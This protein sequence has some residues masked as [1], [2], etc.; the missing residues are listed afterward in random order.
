MK[1]LVLLINIIFI[2]TLVLVGCGDKAK[3]NNSKSANN[4][5]ASSISADKHTATTV[6]IGYVD[7][8]KSF[9]SGLLGIAQEKG[10]I[11]NELNKIGVKVELVPFVG[12]GP[13]INEALASKSIDLGSLG[14]VPALLGKSAGINTELIASGG[15]NTDAAL[16]VPADSKITSIKELKGKRIATMKGSF[17]HRTLLEMLKANGM[18]AND[19]Q[20][21]NMTAPDAETAIISKTVDATVNPAAN[22]QRLVLKKYGKIILDSTKNPEWKGAGGLI[23]RTDFSKDNPGILVAIIKGLNEAKKFEDANPDEAKQIWVKSGTTKEI[24]DLVYPDNKFGDDLQIGSEFTKR[25]DLV[26]KFLVDNKL[27]KSSVDINK[28]I[29]KKYLEEAIK[30]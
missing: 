18:T 22:A 13:A 16:V 15:L 26:N 20:F 5:S 12:A 24:F 30:K 8:G 25:F 17:M 2:V 11:T 29:N 19:I 27:S 6:K 23:A 7:S 14:D 21:I 28:W 9:P 3:S 4:S 1:K 10:Y